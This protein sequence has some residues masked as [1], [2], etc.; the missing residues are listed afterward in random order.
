MVRE[1]MCNTAH[2][3]VLLRMLGVQARTGGTCTGDFLG[4]WG[5]CYAP[6]T[7]SLGLARVIRGVAKQAFHMGRNNCPP[8]RALGSVRG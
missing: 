8:F 3:T 4:S 1:P 7:S 5:V 6:A 2:T